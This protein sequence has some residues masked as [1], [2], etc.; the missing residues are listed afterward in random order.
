MRKT[1]KIFDLRRLSDE[2]RL[3][4]EAI[5]NAAIFYFLQTVSYRLLEIF[6]SGDATLLDVGGGPTI[7]QHIPLSLN[8]SAII[9]TDF[10]P[11]NREEVHKY[12][13]A[14]DDAYIWKGYY[15]AVQEILRTDER[16]QSLLDAQIKSGRSDVRKHAEL[17]QKIIFSPDVGA[18]EKHLRNIMVKTILPCDVFSP[19]LEENGSNSLKH[20]LRSVT[21]EGFPDI[22]SAHFLVESATESYET[23]KQGVL[24]LLERLSPGGYLIMTAIRNASWYRVGTNKVPAV[25]VDECDVR[26]FLE[27]HDIVVEDMQVLIGSNKENHGYDGMIFVFGRKV[28]IKKEK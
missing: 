1:E 22:I 20:A 28:I 25:S 3:S 21:R 10:L 16:Y 11:E 18:F 5:E 24:H 17:V 19:A 15:A 9:H 27:E 14:D 6:P 7:Y 26:K 4:S 23:W 8:V 13:L 12:L 2:I